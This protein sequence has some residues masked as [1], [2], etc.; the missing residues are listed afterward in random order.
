MK[1][2][3]NFNKYSYFLAGLIIFLAG[4]FIVNALT[5]GI[6]PN[7]GHLISEIAPPTGCIAGQFLEWD[8]ASWKCAN[9]G[10]TTITPPTTTLDL[11]YGIHSSK[12]CIAL[13]GVVETDGVA[14][15][16]KFS[17][18]ADRQLPPYFPNIPGYYTKADCISDGGYL[19][20]TP[21]QNY[22]TCKFY[23]APSGWNAYKYWTATKSNTCRNQYGD[24]CTTG[25]HIFKNKAQEVCSY[26]TP[27]FT[28][29]TL[30]KSTVTE[31]GYY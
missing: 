19:I 27:H 12:Q 3:I 30:C 20:P 29:W 14:K 7:Q 31:R 17:A 25:S 9:A 8:G 5:P 4:M 24:G 18:R 21:G 22:P 23:N 26:H 11:A 15:F 1:I 6:A 13:H 16:C 28:T 10:T 2:V